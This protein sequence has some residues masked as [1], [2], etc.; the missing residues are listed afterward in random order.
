VW[1]LMN[2]RSSVLPRLFLPMIAAFG[3]ISLGELPFKL[4]ARFIKGL[5]KSLVWQGLTWVVGGSIGLAVVYL[6]MQKTIRPNPAD[7]YS[8]YFYTGIGPVYSWLELEKEEGK[9]WVNQGKDLLFPLFKQSLDQV[10]GLKF[11]PEDVA[12]RQTT[13]YLELKEKLDLTSKD[14]VDIWPL[15]GNI[16]ANWNTI[17]DTGQVT[18]WIAGPIKRMIG[19]EQACFYGLDEKSGCSND[20]VKSLSDWWGLK[21]ILIGE[22]LRGNERGS[23]GEVGRQESMEVNLKNNFKRKAVEVGDRSEFVYY[24]VEEASGL[25]NI[26]NR[27]LALVIG[28]NPPHNEAYAA[29]FQA[30]NRVGFGYESLL[31]IK[32]N[33]YVD[34]YSL[35]ELKPYPVV[36][37]YGY[38]AKNRHKAWSVLTEY[39]EGGGSLL[40]ETGWQFW[41]QDWGRM[42]EMGESLEVELSEVLPV[43][44]LR[45]GQ[46][47]LEWRDLKVETEWLGKESEDQGWAKLEWEGEPWGMSVAESSDLREFGK[48]LVTNKGKV[49]VAGGNYGKGKV[50]WSGMNIF[51]HINYNQSESENGFLRTVF[52]WLTGSDRGQEKELKFERVRPERIIIKVDK[53][54]EGK[55]KVMFKELEYPGWQ[56]RLNGE[57]LEILR[58]GPGWKL[59]VMPENFE[60]GELVLEYKRSLSEW[61]YLIVSVV[62]GVG[63][64]IYVIGGGKWLGKRL[65][66]SGL[67]KKMKERWEDEEV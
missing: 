25:A 55:Q 32:G 28:N 8:G 31:P 46:M 30:L 10:L 45:W 17:N 21:Y 48:A 38:R 59:M 9:Y 40:V 47:G 63:L 4:V 14:R 18:T 41:S 13:N 58:T 15:S 3:A 52:A 2:T 5:R 42:D 54:L 49:I 34:E 23:W 43:A 66:V 50:V 11:Y 16:S 33:R 6:V 35:E 44:K 60:E 19:Y 57:K 67:H 56:A 51:G 1:A 65:G 61:V 12:V 39:V 36:V 24:E 64:I 22:R 7:F 20:E 27:P 26:N 62:V 37:L 29:V 53:S